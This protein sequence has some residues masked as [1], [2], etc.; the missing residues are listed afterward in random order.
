M[1]GVKEPGLPRARLI[2]LEG[3]QRGRLHDL[4]DRATLGRGDDCTILL[5]DAGASRAHAE[6]SRTGADTWR[7][8]DL[9][10]RNGTLHN[11]LR[12]EE[13]T[14]TFGDR[15]E[16]GRTLLVL[17][18]IDPEEQRTND[19]AR[20][21]AMSSLAAMLAHDLSNVLG[22]ILV[23]VDCMLG[24]PDELHRAEDTNECL[25]DLQKAAQ[26][27][28]ELTRRLAETAR[29]GQ[30]ESEQI[31]LSRL[32]ADGVE[33]ARAGLGERGDRVQAR[34]APH[35]HIRAERSPLKRL[36]A[37]LL[38]GPTLPESVYVTLAIARPDAR[39]LASVAPAAQYA[40]LVIEHHGRTTPSTSSP[41]TPDH[42]WS[43]WLAWARGALRMHGGAL[44]CDT[45][46]ADRTVFRV[47]LPALVAVPRVEMLTPMAGL[48]LSPTD[49]GQRR[50]TGPRAVLVVDDEPLSRRSVCRLLGRDGHATLAA[51]DGREALEIFEREGDRVAVVLMD[52]DMPEVD[53][54]AA[55]VRMRSLRPSTPVILLTGLATDSRREGLLSRGAVAVLDKPCDA[56]TLRAALAA[57][58]RAVG[59]EPSGRG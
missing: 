25:E 15:V 39:A 3:P 29:L 47:L 14:L 38:M 13:A 28:A 45:T 24:A 26:L 53:G 35:V 57:A 56:A 59:E 46:A 40:L 50:A 8:V 5:V 6:I 48:P 43:G 49:R 33:S 37:T 2:T 7:L 42:D 58:L 16:I 1:A 18:P 17:V 12:I 32:V 4:P 52:L 19:S 34:V 31:D 30:L 23:N 20:L 22:G 41:A 55:L 10:S 36:V 11:G 44:E 27:G 51:G 21:Q 9:G 54:E